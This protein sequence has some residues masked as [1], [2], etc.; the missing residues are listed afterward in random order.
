MQA[1]AVLAMEVA[2]TEAARKVLAE[3][4]DGTEGAR[5]TIDAKAALSR[6]GRSER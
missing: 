5:L 4:A 2:G 3:W 1:R 6:L